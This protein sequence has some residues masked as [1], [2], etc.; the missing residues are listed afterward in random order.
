MTFFFQ[1]PF[2]AGVFSLLL[3]GVSLVRRKPSPATWCF[4][5]GMMALGVDSILTGLALRATD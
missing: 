5:A 1:L 4:F 2:V 3:A